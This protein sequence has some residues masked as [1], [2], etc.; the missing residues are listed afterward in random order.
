MG[1][2]DIYKNTGLLGSG[3]AFASLKPGSPEFKRMMG[4]A[5][6]DNERLAAADDDDEIILVSKAEY[7]RKTG[8]DLKSVLGG[9]ADAPAAAAPSATAPS[10]TAPAATAPA[11]GSVIVVN[12]LLDLD[13]VPV[14][15]GDL[16]TA[17]SFNA[18]IAACASL[19]V[20]L[21]LLEARAGTQ[22]PAPTPTPTPTPGTT[23]TPPATRLPPDLKTAYVVN[24]RRSTQ[25]LTTIFATGLRLNSMTD[26]RLVYKDQAGKN[27]GFTSLPKR[28]ASPTSA[29]FAVGATPKKLLE[30]ATVLLEIS[31]PDGKDSVEVERPT[32]AVREQFEL[33]L[34]KVDD[35]LD[36]IDDLDGK[37]LRSTGGAIS[38]SIGN[39]R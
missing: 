4:M 21:S 31:G 3:G 19:H 23:P 33:L 7:K 16:I 1:F 14:R 35:P 24:N 13:L 17:A 27:L 11:A 37:V 29:I 20:R 18:L 34:T 12:P 22:T 26:A 25:Q 5:V 36:L 2:G 28:R 6:A 9:V 38:D 15:P 8:V 10:S 30:A 32:A 39:L